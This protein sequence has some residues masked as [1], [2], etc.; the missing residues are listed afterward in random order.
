MS[1]I[2]VCVKLAWIVQKADRAT[3]H[4]VISKVYET[5]FTWVDLEVVSVVGYRTQFVDD[6]FAFNT[7]YGLLECI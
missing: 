7:I 2:D 5:I 6:V 1:Y 4:Y 3:F